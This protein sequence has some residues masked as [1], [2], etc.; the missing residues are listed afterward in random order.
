MKRF[1]QWAGAAIIAVL[2]IFLT[3][4]ASV[5]ADLGGNC[6]ADLEERIAELEATTARKG[7][8]KVSLVVYGLVNKA[9]A[10]DVEG[11]DSR[12]IDNTTEESRVGFAG[13]AKI[14]NL[15]KAGFVLELHTNYVT[16]DGFDYP[17]PTASGDI[18]VRR[19]AVWVSSG[20]L[21]VTLGLFDTATH[22]LID[23]STANTTVAVKPLNVF[24]AKP[25]AG[26]TDEVRADIDIFENLRVSASWTPSFADG[27]D[28][29]SVAVRH[30]AKAGDLKYVAGLGYDALDG[31]GLLSG[32]ASV[33][34]TPTGVFFAVSGVR[35]D[36]ESISWHLTGGLER[37][38][39]EVGATTLFAEYGDWKSINDEFEGKG[40]GVGIVQH[41]D[42]A[43]LDAYVSYRDYDGYGLA[44]AGVAIRF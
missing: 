20:A 27:E 17:D 41:V 30:S 14:G 1:S 16:E 15:A 9:I 10:Y 2:A 3:P 32:V 12:V 21:R 19:S 28:L 18:S 25:Q 5:A 36:H 38:F 33:M 6:C 8:K 29:F 22:E 37:K 24:G 11:H 34:H 4:A 13:D 39:F 7:G 44:L 31:E 40:W 23:M 35:P 43:A 42:A 26:I